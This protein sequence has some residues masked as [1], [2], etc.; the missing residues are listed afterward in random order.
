MIHS[1]ALFYVPAGLRLRMV[2]G[3]GWACLQSWQYEQ[4]K[5]SWALFYLQ[6][7]PALPGVDEPAARQWRR[8]P[9]CSLQP[10]VAAWVPALS[11]RFPKGPL[12]L[13]QD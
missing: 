3:N 1:K 11:A 8:G 12:Q 13:K 7:Q 2:R 10:R 5:A 4:H 9:S 6:L